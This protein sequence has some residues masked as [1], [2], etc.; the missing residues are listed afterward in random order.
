MLSYV[1]T[2]CHDYIVTF[3]SHVPMKVHKGE[4]CHFRDGSVCPDHVW[5]LST[6]ETGRWLFSEERFVR[7]IVRCAT[8]ERILK[9]HRWP[10][11]ESRTLRANFHPLAL[12]DLKFQLW[13]QIRSRI[14]RATFQTL[15]AVRS[16]RKLRVAQV[17]AWDNRAQ[18]LL[19]KELLRF[20][21]EEFTRLA[22][23]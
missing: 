13:P 14:L 18:V 8:H 16:S 17:W 11:I 12:F 10:H 19:C 3:C 7:D 5:K 21:Y 23:N 20:V 15:E 1:A 9:L 2:C 6:S 22:W 4:L